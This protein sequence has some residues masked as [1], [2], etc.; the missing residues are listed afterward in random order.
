MMPREK[1]LPTILILI[2]V[3]A[4]L[5]YIPTGEWRKIGYWLAAGFLTYSVTW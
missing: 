2:D 1:I 5:G 3:A 4:A